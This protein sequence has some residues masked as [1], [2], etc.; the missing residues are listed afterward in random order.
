MDKHS[1]PFVA[2]SMLT[3]MAEHVSANLFD[4]AQRIFMTSDERA[5]KLKRNGEN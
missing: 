1:V 5:G 2:R 3:C 4:H